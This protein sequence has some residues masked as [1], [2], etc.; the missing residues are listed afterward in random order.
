MANILGLVIIPLLL[1]VTVPVGIIAL[2]M[3]LLKRCGLQ[4]WW[5]ICACAVLVVNGYFKHLPRLMDWLCFMAFG[6]GIKP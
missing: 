6:G 3:R 2:V 5:V 4:N 1:Y